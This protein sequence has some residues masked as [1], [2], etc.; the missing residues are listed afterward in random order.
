[1]N[2]VTLSI[3]RYIANSEEDLFYVVADDPNYSLMCIK[4]SKTGR[5]LADTYITALGAAWPGYCLGTRK[6]CEAALDPI[7]VGDHE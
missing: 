4:G 1:M 3:Q 6:E 7:G 5:L 2:T